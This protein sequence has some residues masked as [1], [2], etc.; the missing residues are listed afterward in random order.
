MLIRNITI[1]LCV[2]VCVCVCVGACVCVCVCVCVCL[3]IHVCM[4][5]CVCVRA[6]ARACVCVCVCVCVRACYDWSKND[7][8]RAWKSEK[9]DK[10]CFHGRC[11]C[12]LS[13]FCPVSK[14]CM[15][16]YSIY[17]ASPTPTTCAHATSASIQMTHAL[18]TAEQ[19]R[20][21][22]HILRSV[23]KILSCLIEFLVILIYRYKDPW[24]LVHSHVLSLFVKNVKVNQSAPLP[25]S[26][27]IF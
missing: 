18:I 15:L 8:L 21:T 10:N 19:V 13:T 20:E 11:T 4:L 23:W 5:V 2:C 3:C 22:G 27:L 7:R 24:F 26:T 17:R 9:L 25:T 6:R 1:A 12:S 14:F 16:S